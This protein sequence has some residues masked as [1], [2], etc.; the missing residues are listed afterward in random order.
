LEAVITVTTRVLCNEYIGPA[1]LKLNM[2]EV[3]SELKRLWHPWP[4]ASRSKGASSK[5][6]YA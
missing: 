1:R 3:A 6:W 4:R 5:L 2:L